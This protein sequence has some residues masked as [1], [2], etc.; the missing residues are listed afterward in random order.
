MRRSS[1][2]LDNLVDRALQE[3]G[4]LGH[5]VVF[6]VDDLLEAPDRLG[7][8]HVGAGDAGELFGHEER[9]GEEALDLAR[10]LDGQLVLVGEL[11]DAEDRD[12]V[13]QLLVALQDLP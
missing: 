1:G 13:L 9:L 7:D 8:R 12:D 4:V 2:R 11:V 10:P 6:A 3:E 5:L